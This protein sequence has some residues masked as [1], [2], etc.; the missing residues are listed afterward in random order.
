MLYGLEIVSDDRASGWGCHRAT[1][2]I[3][4]LD[5]ASEITNTSATITMIADSV[6]PKSFSPDIDG[7]CHYALHAHMPPTKQL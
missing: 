4:T 2:P 5:E 7:Y 6:I 1:L 3:S